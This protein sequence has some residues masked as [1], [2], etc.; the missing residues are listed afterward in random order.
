MPYDERKIDEAV[1]AVLY[2]TAFEQHGLARAW[3]GVDWEATGRLHAQGLIDDPK[4][5]T[6]SVV[7]TGEG[8]VRAK[9]AAERLFGPDP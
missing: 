5:K 2:L 3:K 7:F 6:K 4:G 8:L 9:A 1:L